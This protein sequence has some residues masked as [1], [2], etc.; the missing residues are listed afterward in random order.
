VNGDGMKFRIMVFV[1]SMMMAL[2]LAGCLPGGD[3]V[4][5]PGVVVESVEVMLMESF[6]LQASAHLSGTLSD[7]CVVV[8]SK[9]AQ[10]E[11]NTFTIEI[12]VA[13]DDDVKCTGKPG[14]LD[15]NVGLNIEGLA[16]G[17][18][19]VLA[20]EQSAGFTLT[21]DN[22]PQEP[23]DVQP[24]P[25]Q[26]SEDE[27]EP[28]TYGNAVV[29]EIEIQMD[30]SGLV[31][32]LMRGELPDGCTYIDGIEV[33]RFDDGV[34]NFV[35]TM[36]TA[37]PKDVMCT[38]A[39][40]PFE[41]SVDLDTAGLPPGEYTVE[42]GGRS[43][44][45][46]LTQESEMSEEEMEPLTY[47]T[48]FVDEIEIEKLMGDRVLVLVHMSGEL[49]DSCTYVDG[50]EVERNDDSDPNFVVTIQT[51]RPKDVMCTQVLTPFEESV[52]L[53]TIGLPPGEY[54]VE[55]GGRSAVF[56]LEE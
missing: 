4:V 35:V 55:A 14:A 48:A 26:G 25:T 41:Y 33:E 32:A 39:M 54:S 42:A 36:Q 29:T 53:D 40:V 11:G 5:E 28:L 43:A 8:S 13:V 1:V 24:Q 52:D 30:T 10:R 12:Q 7:S 19:I 45:F 15:V 34:P 37:R 22:V 51:A 17:D 9:S 21:Q 31:M 50:I 18:Y 23:P 3:G 16:A 27:V 20:G 38:Q 49:S 6:P 44:V 56:T 46:T 2:L 47:G